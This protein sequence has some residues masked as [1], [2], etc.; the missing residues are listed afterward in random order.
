M[1]RLGIRM[2]ACALGATTLVSGIAH[3]QDESAEDAIETEAASEA[4][5][6]EVV[7]GTLPGE[8][9]AATEVEPAAGD[10]DA[11]AVEVAWEV[12][13]SAAIH[14]V[15]NED[16]RPY[17]P[18]SDETIRDSDDRSLFGY[19]DAA[20]SLDVSPAAPVTLATQLEV[21]TQWPAYAPA[22]RA[23]AQLN[24]YELALRLDMVETDAVGLSLTVGRQ[25][26]AI[27]GVS[28]DYIFSA[29][30]DAV[31]ASLD[32]GTF[33]RLRALG[34]D[35]V[36]GQELPEAG[37][38][39]Y[40]AGSQPAFGFDGDSVT[41]RTGGLYELDQDALPV[42]LTAAAYYFF[43]SIGGSSN[44]GSGSDLSYGGQLGNFSDADYQHL[45]GAR[46]GYAHEFGGDGDES[47]DDAATLS[48]FAEFARSEG[49]DRKELVAD[50]DVETRGNAIGGGVG[51]DLPAGPVTLGVGGEFYRFDGA[52]YDSNGM[53][54]EGGFT[55]FQ[56]ARVGGMALGRFASWRPSAYLT[57]EGVG[58]GPH[59]KTRAAGTQFAHAFVG[60]GVYDL[61]LDFD[62][63]HLTDTSHSFVDFD[64]LASLR[65]PPYGYSR[66]EIAA[67]ERLGKT[68]GMAMDVELSYTVADVLRI[69]AAGGFFLPGAF[70]AI[71]VD[72][73]VSGDDTSL[74]GD[75]TMTA[76]SFGTEVEF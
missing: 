29:T 23:Y 48:V 51:F 6:V 58:F 1:V 33:G 64:N 16:L 34:I 31:T 73:V 32:L 45:M 46:V 67:Q 72:R 69:Y 42:G 44:Q 75:A 9:P 20:V 50:H 53:Q 17:D 39:R 70:H 74:G 40:A 43:A 47:T 30:V 57:P 52:D 18:S 68:L 3:A 27:G 11:P 41:W 66:Q 26:F 21:E 56:G 76:F 54:F 65:D 59:D 28:S 12:R 4:A 13:A 22:G 19:S 25:P 24:V 55:G 15:N 62:F 2:S 8:I 5:P 63:W 36:S 14:H 7:V 60:L 61:Q 71:E 37:F 38:T 10:D 49:L 35:L